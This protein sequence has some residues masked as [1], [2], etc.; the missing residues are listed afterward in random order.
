MSSMRPREQLALI[1]C[2]WSRAGVSC[3]DGCMLQYVWWTAHL[4]MPKPCTEGD[5]ICSTYV[6]GRIPFGNG[7]DNL[8]DMRDS[9]DVC[10][11]GLNPAFGESPQMF[12][13]CADIIITGDGG[14]GNPPDAH[15]GSPPT[16][17]G[18]C[19]RSCGGTRGRP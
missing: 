14:S 19:W 9:K 12:V 7:A 16:C 1:Q 13:N 5:A 10:E 8:N 4:C 17:R 3:P 15:S 18:P 6:E 11:A 2:W